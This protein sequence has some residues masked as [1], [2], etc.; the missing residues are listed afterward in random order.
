MVGEI[1]IFDKYGNLKQKIEKEDALKLLYKDIGNL[2]D[3]CNL[4]P[5]MPKKEIKAKREKRPRRYV[6]CWS[7]GNKV[8]TRSGLKVLYCS[9][10]CGERYRRQ[11]SKNGEWYKGIEMKEIPWHEEKRPLQR[12]SKYA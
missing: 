3:D 5:S 6:K 4:R 7:C 10:L 2:K 8:E 1:R 12:R 11:K 9:N